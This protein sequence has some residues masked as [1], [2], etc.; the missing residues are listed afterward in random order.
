MLQQ[1]PHASLKKITGSY[2]KGNQPL[3]EYRFPDTIEI[4]MS[5]GDTWLS[6]KSD[7]ASA[8]KGDWGAVS[9]SERPTMADLMLEALLIRDLPD[10]AGD[11]AA[12]FDSAVRKFPDYPKTRFGTPFHDQWA[13][14]GRQIVVDQFL[15]FRVPPMGPPMRWDAPTFGLRVEG[16]K[17][18]VDRWGTRDPRTWVYIPLPVS[19]R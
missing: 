13:R 16:G 10:F 4:N 2:T 8:Q 1:H 12:A 19:V 15:I 11:P 14:T 6:I 9:T 18:A 7:K 5:D 17:V 3:G